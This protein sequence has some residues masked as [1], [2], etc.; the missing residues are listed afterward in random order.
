MA[1]RKSGSGGT[2]AGAHR[3]QLH[4]GTAPARAAT[5][6]TVL[7]HIIVH[8]VVLL[9]RVALVLL[10]SYAHSTTSTRSLSPGYT[11]VKCIN[12]FQKT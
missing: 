9:Y 7:L 5:A 6:S 10:Y 1:R 11:C 4:C 12:E 3:A 2:A 8:P